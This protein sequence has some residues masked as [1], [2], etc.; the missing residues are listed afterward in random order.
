MPAL[1]ALAEALTAQAQ[2]YLDE[3][4]DS[5][6]ID[7]CQSAIR[8]LSVAIVESVGQSRQLSCLWKLMSDSCLLIH[9]LPDA[10]GLVKI[11][12]QLVV[13]QSTHNPLLDVALRYGHY[14]V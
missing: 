13:E 1:K 4:L 7:S 9:D 8:H 5:N 2:T 3:Y 6:A 12:D 10:A 11:P 14:Q